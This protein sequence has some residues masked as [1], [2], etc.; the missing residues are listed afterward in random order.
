MSTT[1]IPAP[2]RLADRVA[3]RVVH[4]PIPTGTRPGGAST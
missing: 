3:G 2:H 1:L 4:R